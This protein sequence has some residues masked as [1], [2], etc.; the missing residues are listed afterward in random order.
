VQQWPS[1]PDPGRTSER[2]LDKIGTEVIPVDVHAVTRIWGNLSILEASIDG[3]G[4]LLPLGKLGAEIIVR[5]AD[6]IERRRFTIAHEVGHWILGI[7]CEHKTGEFRQP[8][9]LRNDLVEKWCDVFAASF[10]I[11]RKSL[12]EYFSGVHD[13]VLIR[14]LLNAPKRFRVSDEAMFLRVYEVL[15]TR[16][17]YITSDSISPRIARSFFPREFDFEIDSLLDSPQI[18]GL[19]S[20]EEFTTRIKFGD[21]DFV[22]GWSKLPGSDKRILVV[23][24]NNRVERPKSPP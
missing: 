22:F 16:I 23:N 19:L 5:E 3:P 14:H 2:L 11:P 24:P 6:P 20:S 15:G 12:I 7:T 1:L 4:Y 9:E 17:A 21:A 18:Q 13:S 10:L 8:K